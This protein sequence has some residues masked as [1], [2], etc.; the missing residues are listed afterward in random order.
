[1]KYLVLAIIVFVGDLTGHFIA[2]M[3]DRGKKAE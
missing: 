1:M 3:I 2:G